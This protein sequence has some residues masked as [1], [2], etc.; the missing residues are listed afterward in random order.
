VTKNYLI[1]LLMLLALAILGWFATYQT[2]APAIQADIL[3][4]TQEALA[5]NNLTWAKVGVDGRDVTVSGLAPN[6]QLKR[7]TLE[8]VQ[9]EGVRQLHDQILVKNS[10]LQSSPAPVAGQQQASVTVPLNIAKPALAYQLQIQRNTQGVYRFDGVIPSAAFKQVVDDHL[11]SLGVNPASARWQ[12][13]TSQGEAPAYWQTS[14]LQSI[15]ALQ[16]LK[17]GSVSLSNDKAV[18]RGSALSQSAS[19]RAEHYAQQLSRNFATTDVV[20]N[21]I[22]QKA[23][24]AAVEE[25]P[26][27][28]SAKYA[29]KYC[30][31]QLNGLLRQE[32]IQFESGASQLQDASVELLKKVA[33]VTSRC[34]KHRVQVHGYTDSHGAAAANKALSK[35]RAEAVVSVLTRLGVSETRLRAIG[36]GEAKP[37]ASNKTEAGRAKNRRIELI[38]KGLK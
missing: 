9:V 22:A 15:S 12:V 38:V 25:T 10:E 37:I 4:R 3:Q 17:Q 28:G 21:V 31:T 36:H 26:L 34:P 5:S 18:I 11:Q 29:E 19:T 7:Y 6:D 1:I 13:Q 14:T 23:M 16:V 20:F 32:K 2:K 24:V 27:V 30:Q 35:V 33:R 8:T